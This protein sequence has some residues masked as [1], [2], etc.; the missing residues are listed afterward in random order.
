RKASKAAAGAPS[1]TELQV[2]LHQ[3]SRN[4]VRAQQGLAPVNALWLWGGG[5]LPARPRTALTQV[6]SSDALVRALASMPASASS[7]GRCRRA[8]AAIAAAIL[9]RLIRSRH[10]LP[11][12]RPRA[13][14]VAMKSC[15]W[16]SSMARAG[17]SVQ[18]SAG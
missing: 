17:A 11:S 16:P 13:R 10:A 12:R 9:P 5:A 8:L 2:L 1:F 14:C 6:R 15:A 3:H 7:T 18:R 4:R